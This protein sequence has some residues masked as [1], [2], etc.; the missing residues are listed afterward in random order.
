MDVYTFYVYLMIALLV[1]TTVG[2]IIALED[3]LVN[4]S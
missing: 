3:T 4:E 1:I 2:A